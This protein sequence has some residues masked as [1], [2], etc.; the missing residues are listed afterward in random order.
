MAL[1]ILVV[2]DHDISRRIV[3]AMVRT[4]PKWSIC[5]EA[6]DGTTG[7]QKFETL[8]PD[9]VV[10]DLSLP[11]ITGI[12]AAQLMSSADP[13]VPVILF[14]VLETHGITDIAKQAGIKAV[15]PKTEAWD[16]IPTIEAEVSRS[17]QQT[18]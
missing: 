2:D 16:L 15:V 10:L 8:K 9:V 3:R 6:E 4:R 17:N 7:V 12:E 1:R 5:G 13:A 14:T 11:D 18:H